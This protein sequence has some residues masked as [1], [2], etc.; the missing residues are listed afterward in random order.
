TALLAVQATALGLQAHQMAGYD[1]AK[2]RE[3]FVIPDDFQPGAAIA[4]GY[5]AG[6]ENVPE[7][8]RKRDHAA[9]QRKPLASLAFGGR[10]GDTAPFAR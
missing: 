7:E 10:W 6:D 8:F 1:A 2:A 5:Y 9:R 3:V 4:V